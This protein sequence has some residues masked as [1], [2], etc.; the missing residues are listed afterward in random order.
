MSLK[1]FMEDVVQEV[2]QDVKD[3]RPDVC[4]CN[5]C[6]DDV[7]AL[8]LSKLKGRY[9]T[10][11]EGEIFARVE[12]S[13]RQVRTDALLAV[14]QAVDVVSKNPKHFDTR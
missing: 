13:D 9:A 6:R 5:R 1:N 8:A 3:L 12:Q 14:M 4:T 2:F 7:I 11:P 10:T